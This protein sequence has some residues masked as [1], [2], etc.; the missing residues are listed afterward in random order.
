MDGYW[1]LLLSQSDR[2]VV[3]S[4]LPHAFTYRSCWAA[5]I[6]GTTH[7]ASR[8]ITQLTNL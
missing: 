7:N 6:I 4:S 5:D 3:V 1:R 8:K 2:T